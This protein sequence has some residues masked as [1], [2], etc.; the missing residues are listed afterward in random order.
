MG[1]MVRGFKSATTKRINEMRIN[2]GVNKTPRP[3]WQRNY[4]E[5]IIRNEESYQY[6]AAY[7]INNPVKWELDKLYATM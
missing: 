3:V 6:I 5:H 7:I 1:A 4:W 2:Q